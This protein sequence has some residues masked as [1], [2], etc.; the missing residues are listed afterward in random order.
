MF[1][2]ESGT[3]LAV[4]TAT[5]WSNPWIFEFRQYTRD[6]FHTFA[7][8]QGLSIPSSMHERPFVW[9]TRRYRCV[10]STSIE[11]TKTGQLETANAVHGLEI[12][13]WKFRREYYSS[14]RQHNSFEI[15]DLPDEMKRLRHMGYAFRKRTCRL[16]VS[17]Y[18]FMAHNSTPYW[19]HAFRSYLKT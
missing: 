4:I 11:C 17:F 14:S 1:C 12:W 3:L 15:K 19:L 6:M 18:H 10:T 7:A 13:R 16:A 9:A 8:G 5:F 2:R